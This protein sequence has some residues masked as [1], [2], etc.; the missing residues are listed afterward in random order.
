MATATW[1][2]H[3][4]F[5]LVSFPVKLFT[6][7]RG[8]ST[9]F[10]QLHKTDGS[11]VKQVLYCQA[12]DRPISRDEIVKGYEYEKG[13]YVVVEEEEIRKVAPRTASTMEILEFVKGSE[14]DPVYLDASYYIAP[15]QAGEKPYALLFSALRE[16]GYVAVAKVAMHNREH[17]VVLRPGASG[18]ILHTMYYADEVRKTDEFRTDLSLVKDKELELARMLVDTL[19]AEFEPEKYRDTYRDNLRLMIESKIKGQQVIETPVAAPERKVVD[20]LEALQQS[21]SIAKKPAATAKRAASTPSL[22]LAGAEPE[23]ADKPRK[24]VRAGGG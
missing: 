22:S 24:R 14:V 5:G 1:K 4:S 2:G 21:L 15:D 7:A 19:A 8:E 9:G 20:I 6:A 12:E 23:R 17:I 3:I 18:L 10:N 13:R 16:T 11:R